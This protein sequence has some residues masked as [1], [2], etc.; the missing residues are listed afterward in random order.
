MY[1]VEGCIDEHEEND[2]PP[3]RRADRQRAVASTRRA[4]SGTAAHGAEATGTSSRATRA[5]GKRRPAG[6]PARYT[7]VPRAAPAEAA[8]HEAGQRTR[9]EAAPALPCAG[10][11]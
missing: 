9:V 8:P 10:V 1:A 5:G 11:S 3:A 7:Q 6:Q 4:R 2:D